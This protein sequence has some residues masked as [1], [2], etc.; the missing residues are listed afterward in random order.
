M[1]RRWHEQSDPA[2]EQ[3]RRSA[4]AAMLKQAD[5]AATVLRST[6]EQLTAEQRTLVEAAARE[7]PELIEQLPLV[8]QHGDYSTRNWLWDAES[9]HH[10]L[11][12]FAMA[13]HGTAV[14]E[15]VWLHGAVW[16]TRPDLRTAYLTGYG[17]PLS[18]T[19]ERLLQ[20][21]TTRLGVSYL[22]TGLVE[23]Q[24]D[25]VERGHLILDRMT[26]PTS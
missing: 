21:L 16:G 9:G 26:S 7:L 25:L 10:G 11:I 8:Y 22:S 4:R 19:E 18:N 1:L 13:R 20:L 17:R 15:F 6:A 5:E 12:D 24:A 23:Q 2:S 3:D 14:E